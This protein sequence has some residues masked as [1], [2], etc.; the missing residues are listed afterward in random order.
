MIKIAA[1]ALTIAVGLANE[2]PLESVDD[3]ANPGP[4]V[5]KD[6]NKWFKKSDIS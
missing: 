6:E 4:A 5:V 1:L 2:V 3:L